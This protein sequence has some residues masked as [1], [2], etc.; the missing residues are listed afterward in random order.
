MENPEGHWRP[1]LFVTGI[2]RTGS[3]AADVVIPRSAVIELEGEKSVFVRTA[4]GFRPREISLGLMSEER[5][6]VLAGLQ[7]GEQYA[8][9][10]VLTLKAQMNSAALQHA[11]HTH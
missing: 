2:V 1:G 7:P 9:T 6:E 3:H 5:A 10:N 4:D 8:A 11:G